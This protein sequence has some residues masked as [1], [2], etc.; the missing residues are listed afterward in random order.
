MCALVC[1]YS[2]YVF[3]CV[4]VYVF[5]CVFV[6]LFVCFFINMPV[7]PSSTRIRP[8]LAREKMAG[9]H[10]CT[11][12]TPGEPQVFLGKDKA[13]SYDHVLDMDSQQGELYEHCTQKLV[14]GCFEG[15]NA[16]VLAYGQVRRR[17]CGGE[18]ELND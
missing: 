10:I 7:A 4:C 13:F 5:V 12:V 17:G 2:E 9:C 11:S 16:T 18:E 14:E 1:L 8:Q 15:Y 6:C 3:V